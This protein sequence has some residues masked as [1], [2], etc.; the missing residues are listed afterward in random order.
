MGAFGP[1]T[2]PSRS[3][4]G[5]RIVSPCLGCDLARRSAFGRKIKVEDPRSVVLAPPRCD[6]GRRMQDAA[7]QR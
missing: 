5:H 4:S 3:S 1:N 2:P 6:L 7:S